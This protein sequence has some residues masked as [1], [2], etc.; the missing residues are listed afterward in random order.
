S[1]DDPPDPPTWVYITQ[2]G[3]ASTSNLYV[4]ITGIPAGRTGQLYIDD[5]KLVAGSVAESEANLLRNGDFESP[6][7]QTDWYLATNMIGSGIS[8]LVSHSGAGSLQ[9]LASSSGST[10]SSAIVQSNIAGMTMNQTYTLSYW[11]WPGRYPLTV[12]L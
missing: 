9:V 5:V 8:S 2:T 11:Y 7:V 1:A 3:T 10:A 12:R 6:L 4:Y